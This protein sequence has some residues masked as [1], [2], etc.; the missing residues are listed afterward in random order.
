MM[1]AGVFVKRDRRMAHRVV[2]PRP[3]SAKNQ[4]KTPER[5]IAEGGATLKPAN[6]LDGNYPLQHAHFP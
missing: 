5:N 6:V 1:N 3:F 2:L 4:R